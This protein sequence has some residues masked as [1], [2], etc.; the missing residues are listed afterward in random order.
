MKTLTKEEI[1]QFAGD[2]YEAY[3]EAVG[4]KAFN[5]DPLPSWEKFRSDP[6]KRKQADAWERVAEVASSRPRRED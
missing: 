6:I 3:N 4:G 5:G 1:T 2:L